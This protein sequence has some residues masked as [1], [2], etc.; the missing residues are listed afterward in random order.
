MDWTNMA[1][2]PSDLPMEILL[3]DVESGELVANFEYFWTFDANLNWPI[4][5]V[6][7]K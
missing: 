7:T 4:L 5:K 2:I 1:P 3:V 6:R